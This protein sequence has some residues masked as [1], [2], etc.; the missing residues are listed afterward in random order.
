MNEEEAIKELRNSYEL[1]QCEWA[2]RCLDI[3]QTESEKKDKEI[4]YYKKQKIQDQQFKHELLEKIRCESL[5]IDSLNKILDDRLVCIRGGRGLYAKLK[6]L[7][8]EYLIRE[9]LSMYKMC[10]VE[11]EK[12]DKDTH[13]LQELLDISDAKNVNKDK[14]INELEDIF[15][16]YQLCE[17]ELTDC[18][19]R[20]CEYIADDEIPPCK[21]CI[22]QYFEYKVEE[23]K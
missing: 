16:N 22:K 4:E 20:K 23:D 17:Y 13:K 2:K 3:I 10:K 6:G 14:I 19:Y 21:E 8:K 15:Y 18:T 5:T 7:D 11:L 1:H 9:Y 12:K